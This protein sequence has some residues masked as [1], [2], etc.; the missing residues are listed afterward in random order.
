MIKF[1]FDSCMND[2]NSFDSYFRKSFK[3]GFECAE[4]EFIPIDNTSC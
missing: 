3:D 1:S 4:I 2:F